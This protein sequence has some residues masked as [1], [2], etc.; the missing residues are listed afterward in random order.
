MNVKKYQIPHS[1]LPFHDSKK[2]TKSKH[3]QCD[4]SFLLFPPK[5]QRTVPAAAAAATKPAKW[6]S[7]RYSV[8]PDV[9]FYLPQQPHEKPSTLRVL[10]KH[11]IAKAVEQ[12]SDLLPRLILPPPKAT[13]SS[14]LPRPKL[15]RSILLKPQKLDAS[16]DC[17][18]LTSPR[19][20]RK[21]RIPLETAF[22]QSLTLKHIHDSSSSFCEGKQGWISLSGTSVESCDVVG[23]WLC[24]GSTREIV[25]AYELI[26]HVVYLDIKALVDQCI[27]KIASATGMIYHF[28]SYRRRPD[29]DS[30]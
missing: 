3:K 20:P 15:A 1:L 30:P 6:S 9:N 27:H 22:Q 18:Y 13:S 4:E 23:E 8:L 12:D 10:K 2:K 29:S 19:N 25:N 14:S 21:Y 11:T 17:I 24:R 5:L 28:D 7:S 26:E 16:T